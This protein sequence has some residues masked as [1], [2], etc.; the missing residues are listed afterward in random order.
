MNHKKVIF[1]CCVLALTVSCGNQKTGSIIPEGNDAPP[2]EDSTAVSGQDDQNPANPDI[3]AERVNAIYQAVAEAYP[4]ITDISPSNDQL[5]D[6]FCSSEWNTLV[7]MV[8]SKDAETMG[9]EGFFDADYW[10]MGQDWG[11]ISISDLKIDVKDSQHANASFKLH[12]LGSATNVTLE[13]VFERGEWLINNFIDDTHKLNWKKSMMKHLE[14]K[15]K[16][17]Q[18]ETANDGIIEYE[19]E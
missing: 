9:R 1:S 5:D 19:V 6:A 7:E 8:N 4:E 2:V 18:E 12:N 15:G 11:K 10:I 13:M 16:A 17:L 3:I 14:E